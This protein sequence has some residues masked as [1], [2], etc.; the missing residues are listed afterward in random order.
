MAQR[1]IRADEA[2]FYRLATSP[3]MRYIDDPPERP[4]SN[5]DPMGTLMRELEDALRT[6]RHLRARFGQLFKKSED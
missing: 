3:S 1:K 4:P 5:R 2:S 6:K